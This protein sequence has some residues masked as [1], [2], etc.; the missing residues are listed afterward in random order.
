M[1]DL[2]K[3]IAN[4]YSS[5]HNRDDLEGVALLALTKVTN[6]FKDHKNFKG[7][8]IMTVVR[9]IKEYIASDW[10]IKLSRHEYRKR[11]ANGN[12]K[13]TI[14]IIDD[15]TGKNGFYESEIKL[16]IEDLHLNTIE[17][18]IIKSALAG[19]TDAEIADK[20]NIHFSKVGRIR[21][22]IGSKLKE[23]LK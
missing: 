3:R 1:I 18:F 23:L 20:M 4:K 12:L 10:T 17:N 6:D 16:L 19:Y 14:A 11:V 22:S 9:D 7:V 15:I 13:N 2:V 8:V 5:K 21:R